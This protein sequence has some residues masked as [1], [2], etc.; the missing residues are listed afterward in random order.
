[1]SEIPSLFTNVTNSLTLSFPALL[2]PRISQGASSKEQDAT[3][4][5]RASEEDT[6]LLERYWRK[7]LLPRLHML[8]VT[9]YSYVCDAWSCCSH[10]EVL[11][12][13]Q[14]DH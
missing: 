14:Q 3:P 2:S 11:R 12:E 10:L 6:S 7:I 4:L 13:D 5:L 1:M 8:H 9:E